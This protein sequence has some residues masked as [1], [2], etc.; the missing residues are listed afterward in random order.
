MTSEDQILYDEIFGAD[1]KNEIVPVRTS[2]GRGHTWKGR[3]VNS[4]GYVR[5]VVPNHPRATRGGYVFEHILVAERAIGR[6]LN[7]NERVHHVNENR[8]DNRNENL[9]VCDQAFHMT[10]HRRMG[11]VKACGS[12]DWLKCPF[13]KQYDAPDN[14]RLRFF[15]ESG[16]II[17]G[18]HRRCD[19]M[20]KMV[21][22]GKLTGN[23]KYQ[24][25]EIYGVIADI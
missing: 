25:K 7:D 19:A 16:R 5:V 21:R 24:R 12:P 8:Q 10:L 9:I 14:L 15:K 11:A 6:F 18:R 1:R 3:F 22:R 4:A 23:Y 2:D 17:D 13:C 20:D